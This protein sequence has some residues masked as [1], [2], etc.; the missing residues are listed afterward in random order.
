[1]YEYTCLANGIALAPR[2]FTKLLKSVYAKLQQMGHSDSG[3]TDDTLLL[4]DTKVDCKK[5][6]SYTVGHVRI[7]FYHS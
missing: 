3:Y 1:M 5:N 4:A 7:G 2:K 6:V